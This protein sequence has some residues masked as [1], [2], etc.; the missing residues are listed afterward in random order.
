MLRVEPVGGSC[1]Q[2]RGQRLGGWALRQCALQWT[3]PVSAVRLTWLIGLGRTVTG[4]HDPMGTHLGY[5]GLLEP[6]WCALAM[7]CVQTRPP[8]AVAA[9][10][11]PD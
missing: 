5:G 10:G 3:A 1:C 8:C 4:K 2:P 11:G 9:T 7:G 6:D